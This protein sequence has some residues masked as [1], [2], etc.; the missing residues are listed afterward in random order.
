MME[1]NMTV[2]IVCDDSSQGKR[3]DV[4]LPFL[5]DKLSRSKAQKLIKDGKVWVNGSLC[6]SKKTILSSGDRISLCLGQKKILPQ[7]ENIPLQIVYEDESVAVINKEKG[8]LVHPAGDITGGTLVN[9]LLGRYG[10]LPGT[11]DFRPGIVHRIDKDTTGL[12]VVAK[13]RNALNSLVDQFST[14]SVRRKYMALVRGIPEPEEGIVDKPIG[15]NPKNRYKRAVTETGS[16]EAVTKYRVVEKYDGYSIVEAELLT[17]RTHQIRVH[18]EYMGHPLPGDWL[19]TGN[20]GDRNRFI[21]LKGR[22]LSLDSQML[23]A[24]LIGFIHPDT[25]EYMEFKV[26]VPEDFNSLVNQLEK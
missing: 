3:L 23:H 21:E 17:G 4:Q 20:M 26:D 8:M 12:I 5:Y 6:T 2:E 1:K 16:R 18:M 13:N 7:P 24:K 19:Y 11:E 15:R 22:K 14:H 9:A 10:D 25:G